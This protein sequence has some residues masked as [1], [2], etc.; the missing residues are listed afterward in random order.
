MNYLK[1]L[2]CLVTDHIWE[3]PNGK[4]PTH[5][6]RDAPNDGAVCKRCGQEI[7]YTSWT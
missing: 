7:H 3:M 6:Y 4:Y 1:H 2:I 5:G